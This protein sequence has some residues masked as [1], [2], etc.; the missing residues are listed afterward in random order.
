MATSTLL[1]IENKVRKLTR[2]PSENQLATATI[3]DYVNT[4]LIYDV[5]EEL[6][7]FNVH[8]TFNLVLEPYVATYDLKTMLVPPELNQQPGETLANYLVTINQPF[9][10]DGY[11]AYYSQ[12]PD[13]F[14][15]IYPKTQTYMPMGYGDGVT[16]AFTF[17]IPNGNP[18]NPQV[19]PN[20]MLLPNDVQVTSIDANNSGIYLSDT[21]SVQSNAAGVFTGQGTGT[22]NYVTQTVSVN[23]TVAPGPGQPVNV[24]Y[25]Q[26]TPSRPAGVLY[27]EN[28]ITV[29]PVPNQCYTL[30]F[31][32]YRQP[33]QLLNSADIPE[34]K[35]WWQYIAYG[36]AK[37]VFEDRMDL[38]SVQQIMPEFNKQERMVLRR[39]LVLLSNQRTSTIYSQQAGLSAAFNNF[40]NGF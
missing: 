18:I 39:T 4:F 37:K 14:Y 15:N 26:V 12:S 17:T 2:S 20:P 36:A 22:V 10:V 5:P 35:Q 32:Y 3:Y 16:T 23:F 7:L 30:N 21:Y 8:S 25:I 9:Y 38:E 11:K 33:T 19:F 34:L 40:Y 27:Y 29:R 24:H 6:R 31:E 13:E 28:T 1:D